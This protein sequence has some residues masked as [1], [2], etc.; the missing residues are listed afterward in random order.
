MGETLRYLLSQPH[1]PEETQHKVRLATGN[2]VRREIW[3]D[4]V[5]RFGIKE[6]GEY[7]GA[8]ESNSNLANSENRVSCWTALHITIII[9][10]TLPSL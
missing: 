5:K 7:Y 2:G 1:T 8:T 3:L 4:F 10:S 6:M 9:K